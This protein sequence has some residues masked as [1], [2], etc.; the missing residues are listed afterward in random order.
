M[1]KH[2]LKGWGIKGETCCYHAVYKTEEKNENGL[3]T[4]NRCRTAVTCKQQ[5]RLSSKKKE[6]EA[7]K[8]YAET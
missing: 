1:E 2:C 4:Y 5:S 7:T 8:E 3:V 6:A